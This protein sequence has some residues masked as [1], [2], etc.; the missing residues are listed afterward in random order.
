MAT[1][2]SSANQ[3]L[4]ALEIS[5]LYFNLIGFYRVLYVI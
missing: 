1:G 3:P 4:E 2:I 5:G